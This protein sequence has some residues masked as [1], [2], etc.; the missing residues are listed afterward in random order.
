MSRF[1]Q[2]RPR[3]GEGCD[4]RDNR[5]PEYPADIASEQEH[6]PNRQ[7]WRQ[8]GSHRV[9]RLPQPERRTTNLW[10][11]IVGDHR[12]PRR[13]ANALGGAV[14][15]PCPEHCR[16][17]SGQ[18]KQWLGHRRQAIAKQDPRFAP[19]IAI[20]QPSGRE[21]GEAGGRL[22]DA[23]DCAEHCHRRAQRHRQEHG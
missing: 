20:A 21:L 9:E 23:V 22:G 15:Q 13:P 8:K 5:H 10:R 17:A 12:I 6:Q 2:C 1:T 11:R 7:Q 18:C 19:P 14:E 3:Q 16:G 4:C